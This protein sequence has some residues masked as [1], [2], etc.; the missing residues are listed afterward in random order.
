MLDVQLQ[1]PSPRCETIEQSGM[2][3][4]ILTT[5]QE[6]ADQAAPEGTQARGVH[7]LETHTCQV[8]KPNI[9]ASVS[10]KHSSL[11]MLVPSCL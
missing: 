6:A 8:M 11:N 4:G 9:R 3:P 5:M 10:A 7:D 2:P 1:H